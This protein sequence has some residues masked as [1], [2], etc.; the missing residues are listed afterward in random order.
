[1][2]EEIVRLVFF[3]YCERSVQ[4]LHTLKCLNR[5]MSRNIRTHTRVFARAPFE[6]SQCKK[7]RVR[8]GPRKRCAV[9]GC[10]LSTKHHPVDVYWTTAG[11]VVCS[12]G[13]LVHSS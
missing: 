5:H 4:V 13:C 2:P 11:Q 10:M 6:C 9:R 1:M 7:Y 12:L 8:V 3:E